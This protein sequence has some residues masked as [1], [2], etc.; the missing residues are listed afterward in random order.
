MSK[1]LLL[2]MILAESPGFQGYAAFEAVA[3]WAEKDLQARGKAACELLEHVD[4]STFSSA[5]IAVARQRELVQAIAGLQA[6]IMKAGGA[7]P[8]FPF[9]RTYTM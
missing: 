2:S 6:R 3:V 5:Q 7:Q 1:S 9:S 4:L 8:F